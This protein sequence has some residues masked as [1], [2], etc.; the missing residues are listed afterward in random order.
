[1]KQFSRT[2]VIGDLTEAD[3]QAWKHHPVSKLVRRFLRDR[4]RQVAEYQIATLRGCEASPDPYKL[5]QFN[6]H[7]NALQELSELEFDHI[8]KFYPPDDEEA[9]GQ[10]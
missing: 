2:I 9:E 3:F 4:E 7:I 6:G 8:F 10:E 5:G 1:M